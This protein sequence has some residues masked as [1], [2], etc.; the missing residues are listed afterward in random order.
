MSAQID[1]SGL[2]MAEGQVGPARPDRIRLEKTIEQLA[3]EQGVKPV[4]R[5]EDY[6]GAA[7]HLWESDEDFESFLQAARRPFEERA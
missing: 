4:T 1:K 3:A 6:L 7:R 5:L 2:K